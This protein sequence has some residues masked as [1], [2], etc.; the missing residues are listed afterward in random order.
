MELFAKVDIVTK[1]SYLLSVLLRAHVSLRKYFVFLEIPFLHSV[2]FLFCCTHSTKKFPGQGSNQAGTKPQQWPHQIFNLL[3]SSFLFLDSVLWCTKVLSFDKVQ[4]IYWL[5]LVFL[6]SHVRIHCQMHDQEFIGKGV[7]WWIGR[8]HS[9]SLGWL[10]AQGTFKYLE[11]GKKKKK[12]KKKF[13][14]RK[15]FSSTLL[16]SLVGFEN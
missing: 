4:F 9:Y 10:P 6:V 3:V 1:L 13:I 16:G 11:N 14:G 12:K 15:K 8:C 5:L 7:P 2:N